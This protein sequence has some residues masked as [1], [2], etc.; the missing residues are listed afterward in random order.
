[1]SA[2]VWLARWSG[3]LSDCVHSLPGRQGPLLTLMGFGLPLWVGGSCFSSLLTEGRGTCTFTLFFSCLHDYN[4]TTKQK[5]KALV[6]LYFF[7]C[8]DNYSVTVCIISGF[9]GTR[10]CGEPRFYQ[11]WPEHFP[12]LLGCASQNF[13][14]QVWNSWCACKD[15]VPLYSSTLSSFKA[16]PAHSF[17]WGCCVYCSRLHLSLPVSFLR[18]V[19]TLLNVRRT[20]HHPESKL[21]L[22]L[23]A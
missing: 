3:K 1:M 14:W 6:P 12:Y 10:T 15:S 2:L 9:H 21:T 18:S 7:S 19:P 4:V 13:T 20:A 22:S 5:G 11:R 17:A 16:F 23:S 8:L